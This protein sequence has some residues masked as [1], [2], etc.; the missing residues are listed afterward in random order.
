[1]TQRSLATI[2]RNLAPGLLTLVFI[3]AG[4]NPA[5]PAQAAPASEFSYQLF[6]ALDKPKATVCVG[7]VITSSVRVMLYLE[8][9]APSP[10]TMT[11]VINGL[12][13]NPSVGLF[14]RSAEY[15]H[16]ANPGQRQAV[17]GFRAL[18]AGTT[19]LTYQAEVRYYKTVL[20]TW[21]LGELELVQSNP[22][23]VTV[24]NCKFL[25]KTIS[26]WHVP[27]EGYLA[28]MKK[29]AVLTADADG[30]FTGH[31]TVT[32]QAYWGAGGGG[33]GCVTTL[34]SGDSAVDFTGRQTDDGF[35]ELTIR[36][37][38]VASPSWL[39]VCGGIPPDRQPVDLVP[40][41]LHNHVYVSG[42]A[43]VT[44]VQNQDLIGNTR[45]TGSTFIWPVPK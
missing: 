6:A 37:Q 21:T 9:Q 22:V 28:T 31:G 16:G 7:D 29:W 44:Q 1:M 24:V 23:A 36:F 3:F 27:G 4:A 14:I 10:S 34:T 45:G 19:T 2:C 17:F 20:G 15:Y 8:G 35:L 13:S 38:S 41:T 30:N 26:N 5:L 40:A 43:A 18:Q 25:V 12:V 33:I 11:V 39:A 42:G 32:W